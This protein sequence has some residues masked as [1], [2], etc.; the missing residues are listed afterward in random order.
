M[1]NTACECSA[2]TLYRLVVSLSSGDVVFEKQTFP[3][4]K[5]AV[6]HVATAVQRHAAE[7]DVLRVALERRRGAP[8]LTDSLD[9]KWQAIEIWETVVVQRILSQGRPREGQARRSARPL[10]PHRV[11][12]GTGSQRDA[13]GV[14][15][16]HPTS[17]DAPSDKVELTIPRTLRMPRIGLVPPA[18]LNLQTPPAPDTPCR[19]GH[20]WHIALT[21]VLAC[22]A[23]L[24]LVV[25]LAGGHVSTFFDQPAYGRPPVATELP[26]DSAPVPTEAEATPLTGGDSAAAAVSLNE[27][28]DPL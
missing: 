25:L 22:A 21:V 28:N 24:T 20:R 4:Y 13:V 16:L 10:R 6:G 8:H 12:H 15:T 27:L 11:R 3:D 17:G 9:T 1:V 14:P 26:F 5:Q 19:R 7:G 2:A 23:W 18:P